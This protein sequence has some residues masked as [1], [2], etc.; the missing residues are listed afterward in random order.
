VS[1]VPSWPLGPARLDGPLAS[2]EFDEDDEAALSDNA[3]ATEEP[4]TDA[5]DA[6]V[7][8]AAPARYRTA[9]SASRQ[10]AHRPR[11]ASTGPHCALGYG[12][13]HSDGLTFPV[14]GGGGG[15]N[16]AAGAA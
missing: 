6:L 14:H 3:G 12:A 4:D 7:S 13:Y 2:P 16:T 10:D 8:V 15:L 9:W 11:R 5:V 1:R